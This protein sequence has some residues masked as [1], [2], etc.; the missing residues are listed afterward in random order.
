MASLAALYHITPENLAHRRRF[1]GLDADVLA[2]LTA[3]E[4]WANEVADQIAADLGEHHFRSGPTAEVLTAHARRVGVDVQ[5]LRSSWTAAQASHWREIFAEPAKSE[6]F[7]VRYFEALL[8]VGGIHNRHNVPLKWYLGAY[9]C[10]LDAVRRALRECPP[11]L[12]P[13][14]GRRS[15]GVPAFDPELALDAE[16]AIAIVFNYDAQAV[17]DAFIFDTFDTLGVDLA[18]FSPTS[19][20]LD[21]S[22]RSAELKAAVRSALE[23]FV[24]SSRSMHDL[25]AQVRQNVDWTTQAMAGI[26]TAST[27]V[28]QGAER[29]AT[30][31]QQTR[32]LS[33]EITAATTRARE[34]GELGVQAVGSANEVMQRVRVSGQEAQAG[35]G[36]LAHKSSEIGGILDTISG[37]ANQTNLLA[38]N[39]AIEAARAG[40]HGRGFAVVA[41]E[42]RKLAEESAGSASSIGGLVDEIQRGIDAVVQL[43][44][45]SAELAEQGVQSS[46]R[47]QEAF[48]EIGD[49]I[50]AISE[51]VSGMADTS[52]EIASVAEQSSASAQEMSSSTQQTSS[53]SQEVS[54]SLADLAAT[55]DRLL[56]AAQRFSVAQP[57]HV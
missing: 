38:L 57:D 5:A 25:F 49:A 41:E 46:H 11:Q 13:D 47:A 7:G 2:L 23:L 39:A 14:R 16:R 28:A 31:L 3:L 35:I 20:A 30:M 15:R 4:P 33:D 27:E 6:P 48:T 40:E 21:L 26:E 22:D 55:A 43:V 19:N 37:I 24:D 18:A 56:E 52:S 53:Q 1:I 36:D 50:L 29:Q 32:G 9:C 17:S 54:A 10:Y 42:V 44:R 12:Y 45:Q 34:L 51:R 8:G